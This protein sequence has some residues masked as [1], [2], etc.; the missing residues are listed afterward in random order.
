MKKLL[1]GVFL[2]PLALM[3]GCSGGP[4]SSDVVKLIE[5]SLVEQNSLMSMFGQKMEF[6]VHGCKITSGPTKIKDSSF[7]AY[8][9]SARCDVENKST[10]HRDTSEDS[11]IMLK[12]GN[13]NWQFSN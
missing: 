7:V 3:T 10:G 9:L 5:Q 1:L 12:D 6:K 11:F 2:L 8:A 13:G 4:K